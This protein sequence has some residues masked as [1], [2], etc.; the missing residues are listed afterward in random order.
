MREWELDRLTFDKFPQ[1]KKPHSTWLGGVRQQQKNVM[2]DE[3]S[4]RAIPP[5]ATDQQTTISHF[6]QIKSFL[7]SLFFLLLPPTSLFYFLRLLLDC[8]RTWLLWRRRHRRQSKKWRPTTAMLT[9]RR[10]EGRYVREGDR[11]SLIYSLKHA[12]SLYSKTSF[13]F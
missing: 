9:I 13:G 7:V 11:H 3:V 4:L 8:V 6:H 1:M 2:N 10:A 5:R 12:A